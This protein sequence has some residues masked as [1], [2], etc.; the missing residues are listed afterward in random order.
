MAADPCLVACQTCGLVQRL[1]ALPPRTVAECAR[2]RARLGAHKRNSLART[3]A[4]ALAALL[5]YAPAN[6]YPILEMDLYGRHSE[7]TVW[8]ACQAL[9][10]Q[11]E[12]AIAVIVFVASILSPVVKLLGLFFLVGTSA[13]RSGRWQRGRTRV[14]RALE[15][16]GPWAM[17]DVFLVAIL[18]A[19]VKLGQLATVVPGRG[20]IAF[21]AVVVLT[22]MASASF[23]RTLI[24]QPRASRS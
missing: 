20:L 10:E 11:D 4:F 6:L 7:N 1:T 15:V 24:W 22:M 16:I 8:E 2:C 19:L 9:L 17:L 21:T 5:F 3:M 23:D 12:K 14:Y 13:F 18:V